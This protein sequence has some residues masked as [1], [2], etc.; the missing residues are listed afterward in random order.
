L[1]LLKVRILCLKFAVF[2][3]EYITLLNRDCLT[4]C[5]VPFCLGFVFKLLFI[6]DAGILEIAPVLCSFYK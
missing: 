1:P 6:L 2:H 4:S 5:S 3:L